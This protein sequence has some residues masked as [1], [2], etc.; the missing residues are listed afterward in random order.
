MRS[1]RFTDSNMVTS[2]GMGNILMK[3][4]D[5]EEATACD[6]LFVPIMES[7][8]IS[9]DQFHDKDYTMRL[10]DTKFKVFDG[11]SKLLLKSPLST[12]KKF[13]V[14]INMLDY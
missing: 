12:N 13:M 1:I 9:L 7:N 14:V 5:G 10:E 2:E 11:S 8:L 4:K 6:L 3:K